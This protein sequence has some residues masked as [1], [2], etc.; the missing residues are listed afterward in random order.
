MDLSL[1]A[2]FGIV[3]TARPF[4]GSIAESLLNFGFFNNKFMH[5]VYLNQNYVFKVNENFRWGL[6]SRL[7][8]Q[9]SSEAYLAEILPWRFEF[10]SSFCY[11]WY[12]PS[13]KYLSPYLKGD[14]IGQLYFDPLAF[15]IA[16]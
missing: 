15:F 8:K 16:W 3:D 14:E 4:A 2:E 11:K 9:L 12:R 13:I 7:V 6:E 5:E 1:G 10:A